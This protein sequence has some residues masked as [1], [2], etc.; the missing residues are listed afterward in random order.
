MNNE[1]TVD[2]NEIETELIFPNLP[3]TSEG[4][5]DFV[6]L[7]ESLS[8]D[9][10]LKLQLNKI[11]KIETAVSKSTL[12]T[13]NAFEALADSLKTTSSN[14]DKLAIQIA[15]SID[16]LA[17]QI[18]ASSKETTES[19]KLTNDAIE[20][21]NKSIKELSA[22]VNTLVLSQTNLTSYVANAAT[23]LEKVLTN[24][25]KC[26]LEENGYQIDF[27]DSGRI[28]KHKN[29]K[30]AF[31]CD[32]IHVAVIDDESV[33]VIQEVKSKPR[34]YDVVGSFKDRIGKVLGLRQVINA[35]PK[36]NETTGKFWKS[37]KVLFEN[38]N[39]EN[40]IIDHFIF[41]I[42]STIVEQEVIDA[43][44]EIK[45]QVLT[46]WNGITIEIWTAEMATQGLEITKH[47]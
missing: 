35:P 27:S 30:T 29:G 3:E 41:V 32:S 14:I 7:A 19:N 36:K 31:E 34:S 11:E 45:N 33:I 21:T 44:E 9:V 40:L 2:G 24:S 16:G 25:L 28:F 47:L 6:P 42:S 26:Y 12:D 4:M 20:S 15:A 13:R 22:L 38:V 5:S 39:D 10:A 17:I 1:T 37:Q 46:S 18:A 43:I 8:L 23:T